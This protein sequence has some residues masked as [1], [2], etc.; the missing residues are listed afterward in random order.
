MLFNPKVRPFQVDTDVKPLLRLLA[1]VEAVD[2]SGEALT[3]AELRVYLDVPQHDP[4]TDRWVVEHPDGASLIAQAALYEPSDVDDRR[5]ADGMLSVHPGWRRRGLGRALFSSLEARLQAADNVERL[6][7]YLDPRH[8]GSAIFA[9]ARGLLPNPADTHT[10]MQAV[11]AD[12]TETPMLPEGFT[13]RSYN[14][15]DHV[16]T[17]IEAL[18]RSF[19]GL[20]G[21]HHTTEADFAPHL[22]R[23]D[24]DG[25]FLLFAPDGSVAGTVSA[26][27]APDLA[28][29]HG[30]AA[31]RVDSPGVTTE[32][33][34]PELYGALLLFGVAYLREKGAEVAEL[35][36]VGDDSGV[37]D[38][39]AALGFAV[40]HRQVAFERAL[41]G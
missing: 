38:R 22:A 34:S 25:F 2:D 6:R 3:E 10:A 36:S 1:E 26:E 41:R 31:G 15:V 18:N 39:Y 13:F 4:E 28:E 23:L 7:F 30:V 17:L 14:E 35:Q 27:L 11:L 33:R 21:H 9:E 5:V 24:P 32:W 12:V 19:A 40:T 20:V 8:E 16:P 29:R 37:I